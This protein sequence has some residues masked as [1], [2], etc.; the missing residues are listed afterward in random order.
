MDWSQSGDTEMVD[1]GPSHN[2]EG[3]AS[4]VPSPEK[5]PIGLDVRN[6]EKVYSRS[7]WWPIS[8]GDKR[9]VSNL[10]LRL[11]TGTIFCILGHNGAGKTTLINMLTGVHLPTSGTAKIFGLDLLN[12]RELI[13]PLMGVC[14]QHDILWEELSAWQHLEI[15]ADLKGVS[16]SERKDTIIQK[17]QEVNL[18]KVRAPFVLCRKN[19]DPQ[20]ARNRVSTFSGGMKRRL[21]VAICSICDPHILFF[22]EPVGDERGWLYTKTA[23]QRGWILLARGGFG[24]LSRS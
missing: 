22:D 21:S 11:N 2:S 19:D 17:L 5:G 20:V 9:A 12:D 4:T 10:S 6:I 18:L 3:E 7:W 8:K 1:L 15:F 23:R 13:Q 16:D 14:P 24:N